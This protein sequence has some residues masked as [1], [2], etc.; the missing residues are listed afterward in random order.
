M[1]DVPARVV[2]SSL[3]AALLIAQHR[4]MPELSVEEPECCVGS[5]RDWDVRGLVPA[6][7][8]SLAQAAVIPAWPVWWV[9]DNWTPLRQGSA[10]IA[11]DS[12]TKLS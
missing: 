2:A 10:R 1:T 5:A 3:R 8:H 4:L 9:C 7:R 12:I 11:T 6:Y